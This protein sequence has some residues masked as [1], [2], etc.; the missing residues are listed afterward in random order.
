MHKSPCLT[1]TQLTLKWP[2]IYVSSMSLGDPWKTFPQF[3]LYLTLLSLSMG[4]YEM[5]AFAYSKKA[6]LQ[7]LDKS[8]SKNVLFHI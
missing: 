4:Q 7:N 6:L 2:Q 8:I 3:L 5:T 1:P